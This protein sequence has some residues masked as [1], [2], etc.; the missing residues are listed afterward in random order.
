[1]V[2]SLKLYATKVRKLTEN[3]SNKLV[4]MLDKNRQ[5][6]AGRIKKEEERVR[7][8]FAGLLLRYAFLQENHTLDEW[9]KVRIVTETYGKP[10]IKGFA[11][12]QYSLSHSGEWVVCC[13][14][15]EPVGVDV[16]KM[17]PFKIQIAKR[18]FH[19]NEYERLCREENEIERTK[20]FY[21]MWAAKESYA[22]LTGRG[23]GA[24]I[25]SYLTDE[26][27]E[28]ITDCEENETATLKIY[29]TIPE[30]IVSVCSKKNSFPEQ[31]SFLAL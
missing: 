27:F 10:N 6:K 5:D 12:F 29:D 3:E 14:D 22:K 11:D 25:D 17:C 18:F 13:T 28:K 4:F 31:I 23:I 7:S 24:G 16:Q 8:I 30:Y 1:M 15:S 2:I 20:I 19:Q 21:S 26:Q 9:E